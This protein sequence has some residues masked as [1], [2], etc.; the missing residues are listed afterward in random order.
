MRFQVLSDLHLELGQQYST[1]QIPVQAGCL[2]LAGDIGRLQDYQPFLE[3][4]HIQCQNFQHVFFILGNHEFYGITRVEGLQLAAK[5][6]Q[7]IVLQGRLVILERD[8]FDFPGANITLLGC[9]LHSH[10]SQDSRD[11]VQSKVKDFSRILQWTVDD[12]N[13]AHEKDL[14]WIRDEIKSIRDQEFTTQMGNG[15]PRRKIVVV[16]HHAP[17][18]KGSSKPEHENNPWSDGFAT[19]LLTPGTTKIPNPL[20]NVEWFVFGHTHFTTLCTRGSVK[21]ISNQRGYVFPGQQQNA[22][23]RGEG[24]G[25]SQR[26]NTSLLP[27][28]KKKRPLFLARLLRRGRQRTTPELGFQEFDVARCIDL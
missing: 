25:S 28:E 2:I 5:L 21:L 14:C 13:A 4:L 11:I 20:L 23:E 26:D 3:F 22:T 10:I 7:E 6:S 16:T 19:E 18:R 8:R 15:Q 12:H 27:V 17:I 24:H 9:T 1:F